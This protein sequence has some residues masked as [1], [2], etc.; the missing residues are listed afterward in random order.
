MF[1]FLF[2][3]KPLSFLETKSG[4]GGSS[5]ENANYLR[6]SAAFGQRRLSDNV[7]TSSGGRRLSRLTQRTFSYGT[8]LNSSKPLDGGLQVILR[9]KEVR[10][11]LQY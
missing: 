7:L 3:P 8:C 9:E 6:V 2:S 11:D 1:V 10:L 5:P 4:S